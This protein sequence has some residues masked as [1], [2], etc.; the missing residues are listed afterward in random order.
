MEPQPFKPRRRWRRSFCP[1]KEIPSTTVSITSSSLWRRL[2]DADGGLEYRDDEHLVAA[3]PPSAGEAEVAVA[4]LEAAVAGSSHLEDATAVLSGVAAHTDVIRIEDIGFGIYSVVGPIS[5]AALAELPGVAEVTAD[6]ALVATTVDPYDPSQWS[7]ENEGATSD[8]WSAVADAD[9]DAPEAWHRTRGN[10]VVVA[11]IDSGVDVTHPDLAANIWANPGEECG[12]SIDEDHNGYVDDCIGWDFANDDASVDGLVG[13]GTHVAGIIAAEADNR[14]GISGVAYD[15]KVMVLKVGDGTPALSAAIEA[16][17]Y[18]IANG[19]M[20][21]NASW[22]IDD[23]AAAPF[24]DTALAAAE[25]AGVLVVTGAGNDPVDIDD[26]PI[27][28][29]ASPHDNVIVVGASTAT[30]QPA[31]FSGYGQHTVDLYA[32]GEHIISTLPGG[33]G[34][35]SGTSMAAPM[36]SGAAALLW[37]ATPKASA[38]EIKGALLDRSDGPNDGVHGFRDLAASDG[39]LNIERSIYTRLFQPSLMYTFYDFNSFRPEEDTPSRSPPR[40]SIHG[41]S[42]RR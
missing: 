16:M 14:I 17:D 23:P 22:Q 30:D 33:Y 35:Y 18:A 8:P 41:S 19:A 29:A 27:Y 40:P 42:H 38:A 2:G 5:E 31:S 1:G 26:V 12:N 21:I 25:Q 37:A 13:H 4:D 28:P 11:V 15:A 39:R 9:I 10:G 7:L 20:V 6:G 24:L 36:V 32:P 34:V 3:R